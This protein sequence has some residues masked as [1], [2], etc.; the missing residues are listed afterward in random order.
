[1]DA[2]SEKPLYLR[3]FEEFRERI[4]SGSLAD[5]EMIANER[6]LAAERGVSRVTVRKALELLK[7]QGLIHKIRGK[8]VFAGVQAKRGAAR[9]DLKLFGRVVGVA[10]EYHMERSHVAQMVNS[11][12]SCLCEHEYSPMRVNYLD[13]RHQ[14]SA[15]GYFRDF[16]KG[17]IVC[18]STLDSEN[19]I[20]RSNIDELGRHGVEIVVIGHELHGGLYSYVKSDDKAGAK[21]AVERFAANGHRRIAYICNNRAISTRRDRYDGYNEAVSLKRLERIVFDSSSLGS[22]K[23]SLSHRE[24]GFLLAMKAF[25]RKEPPTA[26]LAENDMT[27]IGIIDA[28][29]ERGLET[30]AEIELIGFGNDI[31]TAVCDKEL[32]STLSTIDVPRNEIGR[33]AAELVMERICYPGRERCVLSTPVR[34][35]HR[36]TTRRGSGD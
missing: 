28:I 16:L 23:L 3:L 12:V 24:R 30:P 17:V 15:F 10:C 19:E 6:S 33:R 27:A 2:S 8:G 29:R 35:L 20:V 7:E 5:G 36:G 18:P 34:L 31:E 22:G 25:E 21:A 1:M 13:A 4:L 11:A 32:F 9:G 26:I 14:R